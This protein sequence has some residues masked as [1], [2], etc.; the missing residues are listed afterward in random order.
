MLRGA[1]A[2]LAVAVA[3]AAT[4]CGGSDADKAG[5]GS[6]GKP[7]VLT[8]VSEDDPQF[9]GAPEFADAV[10]RLSR[11]TLRIRLVKAGRGAEIGYERGTIDDVRAGRAQLGII[12]V[13][14]W[15]T[16]GVK[17]FR[18][19]L[20]PLLVDSVEL[21]MRVL[22]SSLPD[23]MLEGVERA[24]VVGVAVLPG[25]LRLP[26]GLSRAFLGPRDYRGRAFGVRPGGVATTSLRALGARARAY[27]PG[28]LSGLDGAELDPTTVVYNGFDQRR[29]WLTT[30]VVLWPKPYSIVMNRRAFA[31]LTRDQRELLRRAGREA[32]EPERRQVESDAA[33]ALAQACTAGKLVFT[34]AS[35]GEL[36]ALR[37]SVRPV[38][39]ELA[40][41]PATADALEEIVA[42]R[43][44]RSRSPTS[45]PHCRKVGGE[46][47]P[48][49]ALD[50]TWK[51]AKATQQQLLDAGIDPKNAEALSRL[52]GAPAL[53]FDH[54]R[55]RGIDLE[56]G[57]VLSSG[58]YE[59]DGDIVRLVFESGVAVQLGRVYSL[60]WSVYRDTLTFAPV[61]GN[62]PL[63]L[64]VMRPWKRVR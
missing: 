51:L 52:P 36:A 38:Y 29:G 63:I 9:T 49:T 11:G 54:G 48:S 10:A 41:D 17:S 12:G 55:Q 19:L 53:V 25:P 45:E 43:G 23:R 13:R 57:K 58:T 50:G 46:A 47:V 15:D 21:E 60:R 30:N 28:D 22:A 64:L 27:V 26:F 6:P 40:R 62:E 7:R 39:D 33:A 35:P 59:V 42:I 44:D 31:A 4:A 8:L 61:P 16:M 24:G 32:A 20:A 18:A 34:E 2:A 14:V 3:A 1:A 5:G 56:T 37:R